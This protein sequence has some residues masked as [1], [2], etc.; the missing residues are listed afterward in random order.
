VGAWAKR[1]VEGPLGQGKE[2]IR[3][4]KHQLNGGP[5]LQRLAAITWGNRRGR[6]GFPSIARIFGSQKVKLYEK[7][8]WL[9]VEL[10]YPS[11]K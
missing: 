6:D 10:P 5:N 7:K 4:G 8:T 11:E 9:V 3:H 2:L 1:R